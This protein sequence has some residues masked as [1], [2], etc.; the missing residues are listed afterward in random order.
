M[1]GNILFIICI[2]FLIGLVKITSMPVP[3][4]DYGVGHAF[5]MILTALGFAAFTGFLTI[6]MAYKNYFDWIPFESK[7]LTLFIGWASFVVSVFFLSSFKVEWH[8]GEFPSYLKWMSSLRADIIISLLV[9][10]PTFLILK[11]NTPLE[12]TP[13]YVPFSLLPGIFISVVVTL[14]LLFGWIKSSAQ[15]NRAIVQYE[16]DRNDQIDKEHLLSIENFQ[17]TDPLVNILSLTG[18]F[19]DDAVKN[20]AVQKVKSKPVWEEELIMLL[21]ETEWQSNV[22]HFLDGNKVD[23]PEKFIDP[24]KRSMKRTADEIKHRIKDAN[25]LQEWHFEHFSIDRCLSAIDFQF[26]SL[27]NAN[28]VAEV[29]MIQKALQTPKPERFKKVS[30]TTTKIVDVWLKKH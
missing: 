6:F 5:T 12:K 11:L 26:A 14:S 13:T 25:D 19:H 8:I 30:F 17:M 1:A 24:L 20:A 28:F 7:N 15:K 16:A 21:N 27:P 23:H 3:G 9:L 4:G 2:L 22:Y 18:K 29:Q 10:I